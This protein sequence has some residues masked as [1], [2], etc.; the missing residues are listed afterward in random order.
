MKIQWSLILGMVFAL[1][2]AVFAVINV[3]PV[4]VNL[5]FGSFSLPLILLILGSTLLG[6]IIVG[7]FGIY[8]G[9]RMQKEIKI[10]NAKL[11]HIQEATGYVF[12]EPAV[13][14][15]NQEDPPSPKADEAQ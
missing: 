14:A 5:L 6:G 3:D 11:V 12:P 4:P 13:P 15:E 10:L 2:T 7:A 9:Y 8:R 1:I